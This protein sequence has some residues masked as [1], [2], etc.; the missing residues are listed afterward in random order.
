MNIIKNQSKRVYLFLSIILFVYKVSSSQDLIFLKNDKDLECK[1]LKIDSLNIYFTVE[2]T[3]RILQTMISKDNIRSYSYQGKLISL[4]DPDISMWDS[5][6]NKNFIYFANDTYKEYKTITFKKKW[7]SDAHIIADS[8]IINSDDVKY[9]AYDGNYL[10][11]TDI[12]SSNP[13]NQKGFLKCV[14]KGRI[15]VFDADY[16]QMPSPNRPV[17]ITYNY[18]SK[19]FGPLMKTTDW[20]I[21]KLTRDNIECINF[22]KPRRTVKTIKYGIILAG[23]AVMGVFGNSDDGLLIGGLMY[24]G[25]WFSILLAE[26]YGEAIDIYNKEKSKPFYEI[27]N[28]TDT[29]QISESV[30]PNDSIDDEPI[31]IIVEEN[32]TF[33]GGDINTFRVYVEKN[34]VYP[35]EAAKAKIQGKVIAQ[36]V[37]NTNGDVVDVKIIRSV[38]P[39]LDKEVIR[40]LK[41]S[42]KWIPGKHGGKVV[43]QQFVI[44]IIFALQ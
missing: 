37:I 5:L 19:G 4:V 36:F 26:G 24:S 22:I 3:N 11:N 7:F 31:F 23:I 27:I 35:I 43:K 41:S 16:V 29:T 8:N 44:P 9:L 17:T 28:V 10:A 21:A 18:M 6:Q 2:K 33:Q 38:H 25:G 42:P 15:N 40:C 34:L 39:S 13:F 20:N 30:S 32:A 12:L 1:I 14:Q